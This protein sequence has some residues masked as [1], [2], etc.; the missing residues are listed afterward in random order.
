M[1]MT[2][3]YSQSTDLT[4]SQGALVSTVSKQISS[5]KAP[6]PGSLP[7]VAV[8]QSLRWERVGKTS[9]FNRLA[10]ETQGIADSSQS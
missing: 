10:S 2:I 1:G 3:A 4:S 7:L 8:S 5:S 9:P 6:Y